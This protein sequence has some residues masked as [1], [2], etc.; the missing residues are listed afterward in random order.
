MEN[1][2]KEITMDCELS[3]VDD[4]HLGDCLKDTAVARIVWI[5]GAFEHAQ[6]LVPGCGDLFAVERFG[7]LKCG[8]STTASFPFVS[9]AYI[10]SAQN[11]VSVLV[12]SPS[13]K[14]KPEAACGFRGARKPWSVQSTSLL[15]TVRQ[16]CVLASTLSVLCFSFR[17]SPVLS[18][19]LQSIRVGVPS[20]G[21]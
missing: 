14:C 15:Y 9:S 12:V 4:D 6:I 10:I 13:S 11:E 5:G 1:S 8:N 19:V 2:I 21:S 20:P 16:S 18:H 17:N 3:I 7:C